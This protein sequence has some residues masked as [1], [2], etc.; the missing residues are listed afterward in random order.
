MDEVQDDKF[1]SADDILGSNDV[2]YAPV[3]AWNGI[4]RLKS[5]TAGDMI[6]FIQAN[7][8]AA[9]HSAGIR[10]I[11]KSAV[12]KHGVPLF[13]PT[14]Q[15]AI[16]KKNTKVTNQVIDAILKLNGLD[17]DAQKSAKNDSSETA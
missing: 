6:E 8:G 13:G 17:K 12:D 2:E 14:H 1:L 9:K 11:I 7:E 3:K 15:E 16:K 5:L 4:L 10:L